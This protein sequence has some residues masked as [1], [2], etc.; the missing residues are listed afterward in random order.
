[1]VDIRVK[2]I[3]LPTNVSESVYERMKTERE[4]EARQYRAQGRERA[5]AIRA[6]AERQ[7]VVIKADA[8]NQ[9]QPDSRRR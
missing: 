4:I 9:S 5:L 2:R 8:Y 7:T 3:D 1:M 6:D